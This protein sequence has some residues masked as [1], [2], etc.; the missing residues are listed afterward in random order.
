MSDIR[1]EDISIHAWIQQH[2]IKTEK[3]EVLNFNE[4]P[5]LFDIYSDD[6]QFLAV[7][8][9]AQVGMSTLE[10]IKN[11]YDAMRYK[12]DIIY[13]L[14]TDN[15]VE[16]FVGG[17]VNRLIEQNPILQE[18]TKD[19][20][21]IEQKRVANSM[22]YF[23][24][25]KSK[26]AALMI[27]ADRVVNDEK[28]AS[29]Q[30]TVK[31]YE[32][33]TIHSKY[34][35]KHTLSHPSVP[36]FGVDVEWQ[37]SDQKYWFIKCPHCALEQYM[38]WPES[39]DLDK[40]IFVCKNCGGEIDNKSRRMGRWV[41]K[42]TNC[43]CGHKKH[44][45]KCVECECVDYK[46]ARKYSGYWVSLLMCSWVSAEEIIEKF[47]D[48]DNTE[49]NFFNKTIGIPFVGKGNKLIREH[50]M[51]NVV[52]E[53]LQPEDTERIVI[54][55]D[56]GLR[57]D[58]VMGSEKGLFYQGDAKT[59]GELDA[60][61]MRWK[62]AIAVVDGGGD[63]IGSREFQNR[64]K[65][66]VYL[67]YLTGDKKVTDDI[68]WNDDEHTASIDRNKYI[69]LVVD[70]FISGRIPLQGTEDDWHEYWLDWNNLH[71]IKV[72]DSVT[73]QFKGFKWVRSGRDHRALA[74]VLFRA[75]LSRFSSNK[76]FVVR[77]KKQL[78]K[79]SPT[80]QPDGTMDQTYKDI[81]KRS[82]KKKADWRKMR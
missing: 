19:K 73:N 67:G 12:M 79:E 51:Q 7:M 72:L 13:T 63:L 36:G 15:D 35:Q 78:I 56:T 2:Q 44:N 9:A 3:G 61:M 64:W 37:I 27:P 10:V 23:R 18:Y 16:L 25:T 11:F 50:I 1:L 30:V 62:K 58:Y 41:A 4:H 68:G 31:G 60:L 48:P 46:N 57:L 82:T 49:D 69:Q 40:K 26:T 8:K 77:P 45:E 75:G 17:K 38:N 34:K 39:I 28:D 52:S 74:T 59:Y 42:F 5:F 21:T 33:R 54:G 43:K 81:V 53:L 22:I 65:G 32:N 47:V 66:R 71:R 80:I 24:G 6:S 70:E 20:D 29:D 14:P 55:V 76:G